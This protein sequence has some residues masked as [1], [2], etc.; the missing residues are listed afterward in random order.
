MEIPNLLIN[1][2]CLILR[3]IPQF[4]LAL[5]AV[6][7]GACASK[8]DYDDIEAEKGRREEERA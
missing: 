7:R 3:N 4:P 6:R 8:R 2:T 1:G 5:A